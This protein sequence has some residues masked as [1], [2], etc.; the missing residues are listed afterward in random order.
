MIEMT[1]HRRD[2]FPVV[3]SGFDKSLE[4][5]PRSVFADD[6]LLQKMR[7][8]RRPAA[9]DPVPVIGVVSEGLVRAV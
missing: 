9:Q 6:L 5:K 4:A 3:R 1:L 2:H 7:G 8:S